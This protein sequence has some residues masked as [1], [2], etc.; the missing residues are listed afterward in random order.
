MPPTLKKIK[1]DVHEEWV[2]KFSEL[3]FFDFDRC[4]TK[5][6][7]IYDFIYYT[8]VSGV[9][10]ETKIQHRDRQIYIVKSTI[11]LYIN[12]KN[13][14]YRSVVVRQAHTNREYNMWTFNKKITFIID[15]T[16]KKTTNIRELN[17]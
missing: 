13:G 17:F 12:V 14:K 5:I 15:K 9:H 8:N 7:T 2:K 10:L 4:L 6:S 16:K 3:L 11:I 1:M